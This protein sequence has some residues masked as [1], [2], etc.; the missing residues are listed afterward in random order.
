VKLL[1]LFVGA[2]AGLAVLAMPLLVVAVVATHPWLA[3]QSRPAAVVLPAPAAAPAP[4]QSEPRAPAPIAIR[5]A[6]D[7]LEAARSWLGVPYK[8]GGCSSRGVDCSCL[9]Q[10]V[11]R[12]LGVGL[13]RV[14]SDQFAAT[15]RV[16]H[17]DLAAGDLVFF[18]NTYMPG[19]SHV[20][21]YV[22]EGLQVNAPTEGQVV[23][24]QPVFSGYW[25][26]HYAGAGRVRR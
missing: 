15:V 9:V 7:V 8:F 14:A 18:A 17:E 3:L 21:I 10:L 2:I 25:G 5:P 13:P 19:I 12:A 11:Y 16:A 26:A 22:G 6:L 1:I 4:R 24:I 20:G 23:S